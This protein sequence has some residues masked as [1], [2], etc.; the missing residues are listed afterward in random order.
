MNTVLTAYTLSECMET[1]AE[2][3]SAYEKLGGKN[4]IF[5]EDRLTLIA[6]R[7]LVAKTGGTFFS[8]VSTFARFLKADE[9]A[10]SKQGSVMAVGEIMTRLQRENALQCFTTSA[11]IGN[12][13]K[14]IYETLAQFAASEITPDI[15]KESLAKMPEDSLK[16]KISDLALI[17]EKYEAFLQE[18]GY[19]DE[20]KYLSLLPARIRAD[21]SLKEYNIFFLCYTSFTAQAAQTI[22]ATLETAKNTVGI[23]CYGKEDLYLGRAYETFKKVCAQYGKYTERDLG[24][25][26]G[27][28]AEA[29]RK[30]LFDPESGAKRKMQTES[31]RIFEAQDKIAEAEYVAVQIR[32]ALAENPSLKYRD[33]AL[34]VPDV[35]GY[36]LAVK[37][38]LTE[39]GIPYFVDEKR[40]LKQHPL[41]RFLLD[42]FRVVKEKFSPASVQA[43][44]QNYFFGESDDYRNY[45]LKFANYRGGAKK[46]IKTGE[47]VSALFPDEKKLQSGR[48]RLLCATKGVRARAYGREYC[49]AVRAILQDF[50]TEEKIKSLG[51]ELTDVAQ[52]GYLAQISDA[53]DGVLAEAEVLT[54]K[55]EMTVAEFS[56]VLEDGLD[57]T[58]I[59]LIPLKAD[60][61]FVGDITDSRIEKVGILFAL[62]MTEE[63]PRAATDAAIVSDKEIARLAEVQ[64]LLE[65]T[66]A[67]VN[68]RGRES[69]CLNLCTFLRE[70][71]VSYP[72]S[73]DGSEPALSDIF[74]YIDAAFCG[75]DG[76]PLARKKKLSK[77]DFKYE[78]SA[79]SP[80]I[81][82][83][84]TEKSEYEN[85]KVD[86]NAF[87][88]SLYTALDKLSVQGTD[89]YLQ[90]GNR[91]V[92]VER[93]E[94]L[95][96]RGGKISPTA[97]EK[98]F[99]CPFKNFAEQGL[100]LKERE[101]SAVM[102]T[103]SGNFIH[104][105]LE[106]TLGKANEI[107]TEE[108]MRE[109]ALSEGKKLLEKPIYSAQAD[110][111]SGEVF[112]SKLL[113]EG[114]EVAVAA[115]RQICYS[116][117][118]V[119]ALEE[120][121]ETEDF[122][123]KVDR[124]DGTE[125]YVRVIDYKTGSI[126]ET[127]TSYYTGRK[128]QMQLYM[129]ALKG[130]RVPAG[131]FYFPAVAEY[132]DGSENRFKMK[133]FLNG[134][135]EALL[136]GD[137][138]LTEEKPSEFFKASLK[139]NARNRHVLP[140]EVFRDFLD[141]SVFVA[142]GGVEEL[143]E[144]YI[145]ATPYEDG[146]KYCK[147][148]GMCGFNRDACSERKEPA[149][150]S[151]TIAK[152]AKRVRD[153][154]E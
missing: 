123:G 109:F 32:R 25:P 139:S 5:C 154:E 116:D 68:L 152:I 39:Y 107:K 17:Y 41:S 2:Y 35:V 73:A 119:E 37:R 125:K 26:L 60:A 61:V 1:M 141:Y 49:K 101:E 53:I 97:L 48:E 133:G 72:L 28:E 67:E 59:S 11:G 31:V 34:L 20:S 44:T 79:P 93:G 24:T 117:F 100:R 85:R 94:E 137:R 40:S 9:R 33:F 90:E 89:D 138:T 81:R 66:V 148:G 70:L 124:I 120:K 38:A 46:E 150:D 82:R 140:E 114:A 27:G 30:R 54:G 43:L 13:A 112:A 10:L 36:S 14:C 42:C 78:C 91:Q 62:G 47:L 147:Y 131:V 69:V 121:V 106:I 16:R 134:D 84:L 136:C 115:F 8:S 88:S 18:E 127:P 110:T 96:F 128:L 108:E 99:S 132:T 98:Y 12:N 130:E 21:E 149:V 87:F 143:K 51:E 64:A 63:V 74:R 75:E 76:K 65:P 153:G 45:L 58:E 80:A 144:G 86:K 113:K 15:L 151:A 29:L 23:F 55:R 105:L 142:R 126:D 52:K 111:A 146:C 145:E 4:L 103:D 77:K 50:Q 56:A 104:A 102:S 7:A 129:S 135:E 22:R 71:H 92:C 6:E 83:L 19:M 57:A 122:H 95:F 118:R 3:A